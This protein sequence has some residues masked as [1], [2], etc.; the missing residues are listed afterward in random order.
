MAD[1]IKIGDT[2]SSKHGI[3]KITEIEMLSPDAVFAD[4]EDNIPMQEIW[5]CDKD[6]C[7]FG[8]DNNH[9]AWGYQIETITPKPES[10]VNL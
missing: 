8:L 2:V 10:N 1:K 6:R 5:A 7:V 3:A 9:W 4:D